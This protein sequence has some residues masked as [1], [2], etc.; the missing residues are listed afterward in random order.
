MLQLKGNTRWDRFLEAVASLKLKFPN[1]EIIQKTGYSKGIVS[2]YLNKESGKEPSENFIRT[3]CEKFGLD[4]TLIWSGMPESGAQV[5]TDRDLYA[6]FLTVSATQTEILKDIR[7]NM[8]RADALADVD[9]NLTRVL[10]GVEVLSRDQEI[11]LKEI[12]ALSAEQGNAKKN[13]SLGGGKK[14]GQIDGVG[15]KPRKIRK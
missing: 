1:K 6:M 9:T 3:F 11:A 8:A 15:E 14:S 12:R 4:F 10:T 5:L 13:P 7:K 2:E